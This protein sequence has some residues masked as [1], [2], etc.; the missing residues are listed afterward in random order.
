MGATGSRT[1]MCCS[2]RDKQGLSSE[3]GAG[4]PPQF[5]CHE[6]DVRIE[7]PA[8]AAFAPLHQRETA[9]TRRLALASA[10]EVHVYRAPPSEQP[11]GKAGAMLLPPLVL[12]H[13]LVVDPSVMVAGILF[14]DEDNSRHLA[15]ALGPWPNPP[16]G[17]GLPSAAV[18]GKSD[19]AHRIQVWSCEGGQSVASN[20]EAPGVVEWKQGEGCI[21]T[22]SEHKAAITKLCANK[23]YLLSGDAAGECRLWQKNKAFQRRAQGLFHK[24]GV[25]DLAIDRLF[26]YSAGTEDLRICIWML[27][28]L[29]QMVSIPVD[30]PDGL[31]PKIMFSGLAA[32][33]ARGGQDAPPSLPPPPLRGPIESPRWGSSENGTR[34][35]R[36]NL[37]RR[38]LS[39]WSGWQ[40]STRGPKAPRGSLYAAGVMCEGRDMA[41]AGVLMEWTLGEKPSC[42]SAQIAHD[43]PIVSLVHG[44]YDNGPIITADAKG[45][46]R[47]WAPLLD[48]GLCFLQQIELLCLGGLAG[49]ALELASTPAV[50]VEQPVG[51]YV[52]AGSSKLFIWQRKDDNS[53]D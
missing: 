51:L 5:H 43:T 50:A 42:Q 12:T 32:M 9:L 33:T 13:R 3:L 6:A 38:P 16:P 8:F 48:R 53:E 30:I 35:A 19:E 44:P 1:Y 25:A 15:V 39:R 26:A 7:N 27:P 52:A 47:I 31:L 20:G 49:G 22:I 14:A 4:R 37:I 2:V 40:G 24:G 29:S 46:F 45:V 28:D 10:Q 17:V 34:L 18:V 36:V 21:A 23:T 11:K 41:G